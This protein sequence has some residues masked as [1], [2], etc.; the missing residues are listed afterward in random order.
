METIIIGG[1][2]VGQKLSERLLAQE[3]AVVFLEDDS[4]TIE[5]ALNVGI[6][7]HETDILDIQSLS[8]TGL[9]QAHTV[10][11]A[12]DSDSKNLLI[13]QLLRV[14]FD[15]EHLIVL[16]NQPQNLEPLDELEIETVCST[17]ALTTAIEDVLSEKQRH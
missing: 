4:A 8:D 16:V 15:T 3:I 1:Q 7:A 13:A 12:T 5:Q 9:E 17:Q 10:I 11:V 14:T 2:H 6:D